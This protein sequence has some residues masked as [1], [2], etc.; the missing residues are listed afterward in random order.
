MILAADVG[1]VGYCR[2]RMLAAIKVIS[3]REYTLKSLLKKPRRRHALSLTFGRSA[4]EHWARSQ[5]FLG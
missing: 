4:R 5:A 3:R 1:V 2:G